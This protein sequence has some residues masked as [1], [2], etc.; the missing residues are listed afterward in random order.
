MKKN[1]FSNEELNMLVAA[2]SPKLSVRVNRAGNLT[3]ENPKGYGT[4]PWV[5][6]VTAYYWTLYKTSNGYVWR[7][8][9]SSSGYCYPLNMVKRNEGREVHCSY[10]S[11]NGETLNTT[12]TTWCYEDHS[13]FKTMEEAVNYFVMYVT[14]YRHINL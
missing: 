11:P 9:N 13:T 2:V 5:Y 8:L 14:K 7:C 12:Y 1:N 4:T 6:P 10:T 3:V